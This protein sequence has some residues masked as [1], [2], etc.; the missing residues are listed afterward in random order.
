[1]PSVLT[2][3]LSALLDEMTLLTDGVAFCAHR[4]AN[5][6]TPARDATPIA[7]SEIREIAE[8][9]SGD[10]TRRAWRRA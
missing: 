4:I 7:S 8:C 6:R 5:A 2:A 10:S 3:V 9:A 1:M